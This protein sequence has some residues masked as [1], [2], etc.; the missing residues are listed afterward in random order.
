MTVATV[1]K[2]TLASRSSSQP[3]HSP[4]RPALGSSPYKAS[5]SPPRGQGEALHAHTQAREGM[6]NYQQPTRAPPGQGPNLPGEIGRG[7]PQPLPQPQPQQRPQGP[8]TS[9]TRGRPTAAAGALGGA[10]PGSPRLPG[11][12]SLCHLS[13]QPQVPSESAVLPSLPP[14]VLCLLG[15]APPLLVPQKPP[16]LIAQPRA[17]RQHHGPAQ[18]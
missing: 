9:E 15:R 10:G 18:G 17:A 3:G 11:L 8:G 12:G 4:E 13:L 1:L 16:G 14:R 2:K 5:V 6:A 7:A